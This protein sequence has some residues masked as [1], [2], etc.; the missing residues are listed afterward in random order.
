MSTESVPFWDINVPL[1]T[2]PEPSLVE[3]TF[4]SMSR[5]DDLK[6]IVPPASTDEIL[7]V[8]LIL[9]PYQKLTQPDK[10]I[11]A[12]TTIVRSFVKHLLLFILK[13]PLFVIILYLY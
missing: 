9:T 8:V 13:N 7:F 3:L 11:A 1:A 10:L 4:H 6:F 5:P 2:G 12:N